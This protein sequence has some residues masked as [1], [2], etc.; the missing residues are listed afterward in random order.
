MSRW[1][2]YHDPNHL[3]AVGD[4]GYFA[5]GS[6]PLYDGS[7][8][9]DTEAFLRIPEID[10]G[11]VHLYPQ[12]WKQQDP[13]LFGIR[14]IEQH[15]AAG[16]DA[17]KPV[18]IEEYGMTVAP[19]G[20]PSALARN[21]VYRYWLNAILSHGGAGDLAW[22][23]ASRDDTT[24]EPYP[25]YDHFTFYST[26]DVMSIRDHVLQMT[27]GAPVGTLPSLRDS[28]EDEG[29]VNLWVTDRSGV[30]LDENNTT[31]VVRR[32]GELLGDPMT[33]DFSGGAVQ[34]NLLAF[35]AGDL[36]VEI[37]P[38]G[39]EPC[40]SAV[41]RIRPQERIFLHMMTDRK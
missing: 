17:G 11:T 28:G 38:A 3:L 41:F 1:V 30:F 32:D 6:G 9:V 25:D 26:A 35:P 8:G 20:L 27:K 5:N 14:W 10:F 29:M 19:D 12:G 16:R 33:L 24:G 4:Q 31:L 22:M 34:L 36:V 18:L 2:K 37:E 13:I 39:Y 15:L 21:L 7:H 40:A 23:I